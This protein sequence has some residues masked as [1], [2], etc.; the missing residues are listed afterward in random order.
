MIIKTDMARTR[1]KNGAKAKWLTEH[2]APPCGSISQSQALLRTPRFKKSLLEE[3]L[4]FNNGRGYFLG[5]YKLIEIT[6]TWL[7]LF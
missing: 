2:L 5:E 6:S 3:E 7:A 4:G 1:I